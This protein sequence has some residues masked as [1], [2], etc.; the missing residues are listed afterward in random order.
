MVVKKKR[1]GG[2]AVV[3]KGAERRGTIQIALLRGINVGKAKRIAM[4]DLRSLVEELGYGDV[5]TLLNSGNVVFTV[6]P[7]SK[8]DPAERI[9]RGIAESLGV[10]SRVTV[11]TAAEL[12]TLVRRNPLLES[13]DDPSRLLV[14][15][16][17]DPGAKAKL[18]PLARQDW[19]PDA[20]A[21]GE[22]GA[23]LW[24][25]SGILE[26]KLFQ[27]A[28]RALGDSATSRNWATL[29]KLHALAAGGR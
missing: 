27:A 8:G 25:A 15:V 16:F 11:L 24:C 23:Y 7:G 2:K 22:R 26:G 18:A 14:S 20:L 3:R 13:M 19:S 5:R 12:A 6:P 9:E 21:L 29:L 17:T 28:A 1:A 4:A 10:S